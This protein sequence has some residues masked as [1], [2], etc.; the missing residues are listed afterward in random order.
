MQDIS[1]YGIARTLG[2]IDDVKASTSDITSTYVDQAPVEGSVFDN[3]SHP[4]FTAETDGTASPLRS[5]EEMYSMLP[6][7]I[8]ADSAGE[9]APEDQQHANHNI[10]SNSSS[11]SLESRA[12]R[13]AN[14]TRELVS[15]SGG[16]LYQRRVT[17]TEYDP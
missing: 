11:Q 14:N 3:L 9:S 12:A 7:N 8:T 17:K 10:K 16:D 6:A 1:S 5:D 2:V 13:A 15:N 4:S